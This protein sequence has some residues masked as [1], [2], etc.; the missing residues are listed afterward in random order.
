M[1]KPSLDGRGRLEL[2]AHQLAVVVHQAERQFAGR[3]A[4]VADLAHRRHLGGRT[5]QETFGKSPSPSGRMSRT[6]TSTPR[7]LAISITVWRVM[8]SRMW[9]TRGVCRTPCLTKKT[10]APVASAT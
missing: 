6:T 8:P 10:L 2:P 7:A 3:E 1:E 4:M 9:S 5:G